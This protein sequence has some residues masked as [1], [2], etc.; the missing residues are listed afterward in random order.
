VTLST[1]AS[2][3][4]QRVFRALADPTRRQILQHLQHADMTI[5]E[6]TDHFDITRAAIKKHL[7]ILEEGQLIYVEVR[8]RERINHFNSDGLDTA[9]QWIGYFW[10]ER[11]VKL[12]DAVEKSK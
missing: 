8:G 10:D 7:N 3:D 2:P 1:S 11:L 12:K 9:A 6:V 5:R 4:P